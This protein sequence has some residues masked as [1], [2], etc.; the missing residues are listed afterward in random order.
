MSELS[1]GSLMAWNFA[2]IETYRAN[3][4][5][6]TPELL[7]CG[8]TKLEDMVNPE[9]LHE[10]GLPKHLQSIYL[11]EISMLVDAFRKV[12]LSPRQMRHKLRSTVGYGGFAREN[13][14]ETPINRSA[15]TKEIFNKAILSVV[16]S[17]GKL[18][19]IADVLVSLLE[20]K[21]N[22]IDKI[23]SELNINIPL[24]KYILVKDTIAKIQESFN[25]LQAKQAIQFSP[26]FISYSHADSE[27]VEKIEGYLNKKGIGFWRDIHDMKSGRIEKQIDHAMRLNPTVLLI[28][29][30]DSLQSDWVEH[31]VRTARSLEKEMKKDVLCPV[32]VDD[33]WKN[34]PWAKRIMEQI[35]EY[36]ILDF[37]EWKDDAKFDNTFNKLIDGLELFYK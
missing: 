4:E 29:S 26:L 7:F 36:N 31:E 30:K 9:L 8:I 16:E 21:N 19:T 6:I 34:S 33:T 23:L 5:E 12:N 14:I 10:V 27:F 18:I 20:H 17:G 28:L 11:Q 13:K 22:N 15:Q 32:A 37:S 3:Y 24:L 35:M 1:V 25:E 2:T